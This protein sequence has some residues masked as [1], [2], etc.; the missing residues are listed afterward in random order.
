M[1]TY[2]LEENEVLLIRDVA[3]LTRD[4]NRMKKNSQKCTVLLTN[5]S[6]IFLVEEKK[7]QNLPSEEIQHEI[8]D[9]KVYDKTIQITRK[10]E[11]VDIYFKNEVLYLDFEN[12]KAATTFCDK[13]LKLISGESKLV[14]TVN[15]IKK[16]IQET[17]E[18]LHISET[19]KKA[20]TFICEA[21]SEV[22]KLDIASKKT[23]IAGKIAEV[24][25]RKNKKENDLLESGEA[26]EFEI[27]EEPQA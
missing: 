7:S 20:T 23:K 13:A 24:F 22:A 2:N 25:L 3:S 19:T 9:V 14:R 17:D 5:L 11:S 8:S 12:E 27:Q 21:T 1:Q 15:K 16:C 6:F 4:W 10:K 26:N 18:G